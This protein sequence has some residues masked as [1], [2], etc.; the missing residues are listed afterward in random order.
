M[1]NLDDFDVLILPGIGGSGPEHWQTHW[2]AAFPQFRRVQQSSW[3]LP[4]YA[5]WARSLSAAIEQCKKPAV[6]VAHSLGTCLTV[7]WAAEH[8]ELASRVAGAFLVATTDI[9]RF[10]GKGGTPAL[11]FAPTLMQALPF[12]SMVIAS[13][14]DERVE[15]ARSAEFA[16]AWGSTLVDAGEMGHIGS[17]AKLGVWP[18]GLVQFGRFIASLWLAGE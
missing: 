5:D 14:N 17:A 10:E 18:W 7:R 3:D 13:H 15:F 11:G 6:L 4:V 2:E 1:R 16:Q 8:P 12:H 9:G